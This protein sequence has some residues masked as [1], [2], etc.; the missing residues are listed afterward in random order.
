[1]GPIVDNKYHP[2]GVPPY[3]PLNG[4]HGLI[5]FDAD[6]ANREWLLRKCPES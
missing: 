5:D 3:R 2:D 4:I 1:M 6:A